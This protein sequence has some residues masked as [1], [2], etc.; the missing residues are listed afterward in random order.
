MNRPTCEYLDNPIGIGDLY[1]RFSWILKSDETC[2]LQ[3]SYRI[4]VSKG[5]DDFT[6]PVWDSGVIKSDQ[7]VNIVYDGPSLDSRTRY[8]Y[9]IKLTDNKGNESGW[10][11]SHFFETGILH[12][13]EWKADFISA[14]ID[15][16]DFS[17]SCPLFRKE[18]STKG[19]IRSA[20]I[21]STSL[22][23]YEL[24]INGQ[25]VGEDLFAPGWTDYKKRLQCQT[26]DV[27]SMLKQG[28]N[29]VC[30]TVSNGWY[31][32]YLANCN[33]KNNS[34]Y[35]N[36]T[37]LSLMLYIT[38]QDGSE[39]VILADESWKTTGGPILMSEFYHGETYDARLE[40]PGWDLPD[41]DD[42]AWQPVHLV[43]T[44][45][46]ILIPQEG[47]PVRK[48]ET[49]SPIALFKTPKGETV[50]DMGQNMVGWMRFSVKGSRGSRVIL[51]HAEVLDEEGGFYTENLRSARQTI[52]YILKGDGI[53]TFEPHFTFQGFRYVKIEAYPG[54]PDKNSFTGVVIHSDMKKTG[55]F[56]CSNNLVNQLYHNILWGQKGNF[57]DIPTDCPQRDERLGWTGDAQVFARTACFNMNTAVFYKKWLHDLKSDQLEDGSVPHVVPHILAS[58]S[59]SAT[60][61]A[62]AA[63]I[64]PWTVYLCFG[65]KRILAEQY[66]SMKAWVSYIRNH[67]ENGLIWN[68]GSH[69]GDWL[70]LDAEEGSCCGATPND[71]TATAF[72]AYSAR[73]L[74]KIA[75][76]L[77]KKND[78]DEYNLLYETIAEAFRNEFITPCGRLAAD[79]Q[80]ACVL[81]LMF[82]LADKKDK[83]RIINTLVKMLEDNNWHLKTGF[84]GTPYLCH[85]L[86]RNGRV[87]AAYKL[88]L[89]TDYPSW[90]YPITKGA[91]TIWEHWDGIKP[92][93][94]FW[95]SDMNSYNHYAY[96]TVGDWMFQV[97][98]GLDIDE[99]SPGYK[100]II[101]KPLPGE[102]IKHAKAFL[103]TMYGMAGI[104]WRI[105]N[106][107]MIIEV[108]IPPNTTATLFFPFLT[109]ASLVEMPENTRKITDIRENTEDIT[110]KLGSGCYSFQYEI[111]RQDNV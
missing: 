70:A 34:L 97:M 69:F 101:F 77:N 89:Q 95:S 96:G 71:L 67:A 93:G 80:T 111:S 48:I 66:E 61:W 19:I 99:S 2:V 107:R 9:R 36:R 47:L 105:E 28:W 11:G 57:V 68:T 65:D 110:V 29:A 5:N 22:G 20:R 54:E 38:C 46:R 74:A 52:E 42:S 91:T 26:Y 58:D 25:R 83:K 55:D 8:F 100:H 24:Y 7:S 86:S 84:L 12:S 79:T 35:G 27:A 90:I 40:I 62:D 43:Q 39:E 14:D 98:A 50:L 75:K 31:K 88:L 94:S 4:Q 15:S 17:S 16:P 59:Y 56:S 78:A 49:L 45:K 37:A 6:D 92:D 87:D 13:E 73:L 23:I 60:G 82:D 51:K 106:N 64:C 108:T 18:F 109:D 30:A 103:D 76:A 44:D 53:E 72:Y 85:V 102:G 21:Y 32:G 104:Q 1:P 41:F 33:K 10:S 63:V 3:S 81:V